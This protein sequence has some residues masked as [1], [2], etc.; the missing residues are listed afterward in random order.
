LYLDLGQNGDEKVSEMML[1]VEE[2]EEHIAKVTLGSKRVTET[3]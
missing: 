3:C 2:A 1:R